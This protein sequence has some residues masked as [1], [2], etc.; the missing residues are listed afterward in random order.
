MTAS[1]LIACISAL[2]SGGVGLLVWRIQK[3]ID[4]LE[5]ETEKRHAAQVEMHKRERELQL[6]MAETTRLMAKKLYDASSVNGDLE[7]SAED[8]KKSQDALTSYTR[9]IGISYVEK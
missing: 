3:H 8:L 4:R 1:I 2:I 6:A 9:E 5:A 7:K